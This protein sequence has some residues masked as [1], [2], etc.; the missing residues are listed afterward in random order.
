MASIHERTVDFLRETAA[1]VNPNGRFIYGREL[2]NSFNSYPTNSTANSSKENSKPLISLLPFEISPSTSPDSSF[3]TASISLIFSRSADVADDA[4]R[5]EEIMNEM[6]EIAENFLLVINEGQQKPI[7]YD[8]ENIRM[9][10][11]YQIWMGTNSGYVVTFT[12]NI[13]KDCNTSEQNDLINQFKN[14][15]RNA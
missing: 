9:Q 1:I 5:E 8:I 2:Q 13:K 11:E 14:R 3:D 4:S 10:A 15:N 12:L 6:S 7:L